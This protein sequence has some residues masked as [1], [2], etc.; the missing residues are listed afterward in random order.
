[1]IGLT[2]ALPDLATRNTSVQLEAPKH[3]AMG[4]PPAKRAKRTDNST[5]SDRHPPSTPDEAKSRGTNGTRDGRGRHGDEERPR[6][7]EERR[8]RS[9][10]R[11]KLRE[12]SRSREMP[13][14][15]RDRSHS[16]ERGSRRHREGDRGSDRRDKD[17]SRSR[18]R[19][20]G[21]HGRQPICSLPMQQH[22]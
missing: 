13:E 18:D 16:R 15:R 12:R 8:N 19:R 22:N 21:H 20:R 1:M 10:S 11:G 3:E 5:I 4:E 14:K 6:G 17:R 2:A 7:K 9:R